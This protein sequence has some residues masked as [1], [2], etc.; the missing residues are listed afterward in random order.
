MSDYVI[1]CGPLQSNAHPDINRAIGQINILLLMRCGV[2]A[3]SFYSGAEQPINM[4]SLFLAMDS[5]V[6][7]LDL[8]CIV[9]KG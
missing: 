7:L 1:S 6:W 3:E 2:M 5:R 9:G 4:Q 8:G